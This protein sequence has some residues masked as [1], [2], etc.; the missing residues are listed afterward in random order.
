MN[1]LIMG[2][3]DTRNISQKIGARETIY[4]ENYLARRSRPRPRGH[5]GCL[6]AE[7]RNIARHQVSPSSFPGLRP[8]GFPTTDEYGVIAAMSTLSCKEQ[9][10]DTQ[11]LP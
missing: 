3:L 2:Y 1:L 7:L 6:P 5:P 10:S 8:R 4:V 11:P 9:Q